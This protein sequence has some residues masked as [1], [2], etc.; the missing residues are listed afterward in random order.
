MEI[1]GWLAAAAIGMSGYSLLLWRD[2]RR[3]PSRTLWRELVY[4]DDYISDLL[5]EPHRTKTSLADAFQAVV[6]EQERARH[7][8]IERG[9]A[10]VVEDL[11]PL[12]KWHSELPP[13]PP[14]DL[15]KMRSTVA[16]ALHYVRHREMGFG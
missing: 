11:R 9:L 3:V 14:D 5:G 15:R 4:L 2:H 13:I 7:R 1:E 8:S 16:S 10:D 12:T 6:I